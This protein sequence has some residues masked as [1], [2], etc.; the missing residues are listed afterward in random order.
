[1]PRRSIDLVAP[2]DLPSVVGLHFRGRGDPTG[3][4]SARAVV[5][6]TRTPDGPAT[7]LAE[8][9]GTRIE[10][11]SWGPGAD[12]ALA[13]L[14]ALLGLDDDPT[15]FDPVSRRSSRR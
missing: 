10:A 1:M 4:V 3:R 14:P 15:G 2:L 5:R 7:L 6:A 12:Q 13:G 11:E 9:R 8:L